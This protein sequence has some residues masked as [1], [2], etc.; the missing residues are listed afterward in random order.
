MKQISINGNTMCCEDV[1]CASSSSSGGSTGSFSSGYGS[2]STVVAKGDITNFD[3]KISSSPRSP[4]TKSPKEASFVQ[5][6]SVSQKTSLGG[7]KQLKIGSNND[8]SSTTWK[9]SLANPSAS[10]LHNNV[11][12]SAGRSFYTFRFLDFV[13]SSMQLY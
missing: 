13:C 10:T 7:V 5:A 2:Q 4:T 1:S 9:R 6:Q 8:A 12:V 3:V 11:S